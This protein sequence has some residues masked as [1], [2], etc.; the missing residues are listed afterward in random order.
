MSA[1]EDAALAGAGSSAERRSDHVTVTTRE[2]AYFAAVALL[3][4]W[5][6][7][8]AYL[9]PSKVTKV[10]PFEVPPLHSRFIG[11]VYL[12]GFALMVSALLARRWS[13][14]RWIPLMTAI[15]TG[16][17]LVITL[18]HHDDF[19]FAKTQTQVWFGAY[20]AYPLIGIWIM[21]EHRGDPI[22]DERGPVPAA[23]ARR[24]LTAQGV[25]LC[26]AGLALL[27]A[28]GTMADG[29][30]W[31]VT[32]LLAQIYSAPLLSYGV[33]SLLFARVRRWPEMQVGVA[34]IGLF[35]LGALIASVVHRELFATDDPAAWAW[36][37]ALA[38]MTAVAALL[39]VS[40]RRSV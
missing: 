20:V 33:G 7:F 23:W 26:A 9:A 12:S 37:G 14:I 29:W 8:P 32:S 31:P 24:C 10:L 15:W 21:L 1:R 39:V 22:A 35:A 4:G 40:S 36:F 3:A 18:L 27:L 25:V 5:V 34:G 30:P 16:G 11:A 13:S 19:D 6:G 28:P 17:L 38:A 2:R